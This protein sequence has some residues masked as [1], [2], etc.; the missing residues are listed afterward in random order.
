MAVARATGRLS[1]ST[2]IAAV[3]SA[4]LLLTVG[5]AAD[6]LVTFD[7]AGTPYT[8]GQCVGLSG[9][10][11]TLIN[12][13]TVGQFMRLAGT[14]VPSHGTIAMDRSNPGAFPD[15]LSTF[16]IRMTSQKGR[17][18]GMGMALL[19]TAV[20]GTKGAVCPS[21]APWAAEQPNFPQSLGIGFDIYKNSD[22]GDLNNN[23][24]GIHFDG[25]RVY[26]VDA[27]PIDLASGQWITVVVRVRAT[28]TSSSQV[29][30]TLVPSDG[31][32]VASKTYGPFPVTGLV[33]YE[34]R[35]WFG[36]RSGGESAWQDLDDV[37]VAYMS[38]AGSTTPLFGSVTGMSVN[39]V[40]C[41]NLATGQLV[42][43][44]PT[45]LPWNCAEQ[46]LAGHAGDTVRQTVTGT[47]TDLASPGGSPGP[48]PSPAPPLGSAPDNDAW[49]AATSIGSLPFTANQSV[50]GATAEAGEQTWCG[51]EPGSVWFNYTT[52]S[53]GFVPPELVIS[54]L[55]SDFQPVV[56]VF[57][58]PY[59]GSPSVDRL[60]HLTCDVLQTAGTSAL[61]L[62][63]QPATTYSVQVRPWVPLNTF[64]TG[65][66]KLSV[67][68]P[69]CAVSLLS[70]PQNG[71][72]TSGAGQATCWSTRIISAAPNPGFT[73]LNWTE[74]GIVLSTAAQLTVTLDSNRTLTAHFQST[75]STKPPSCTSDAALTAYW[76]AEG[77]AVNCVDNTTGVFVSGATTGPGKLG[78]GFLLN[79]TGGYLDMKN[80]TNVQ[81][82]NSPSGFS[83]A[84]FVRFNALGHPPGNN[85]GGPQGDMSIVDKMAGPPAQ[86]INWEGWRLLKQNDNHFWFCLGGSATSGVYIQNGCTPDGLLTVR[87]SMTAQTGIW[88]HLVAVKTSQTLSLYVNGVLD[89]TRI[90]PTDVNTGR[91]S[92]SLRIGSYV[93]EGAFLNGTV[94]EVML[95]RRPLTNGEVA[96]LYNSIK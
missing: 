20:F 65:K 32:P 95:F 91:N 6:T 22:L 7:T 82:S 4:T 93:A 38:T 31:V 36:G 35:L 70:D 5:T 49:A 2:K 37:R 17:A 85:P 57:Q 73:F 26:Q 83:V 53:T 16:R 74:N 92:A 14:T 94:D 60:V 46:G 29:T 66:L 19:N 12:E 58:N 9:P 81:V 23:H 34:S 67:S 84:A 13:S 80:G 51:G 52:P 10:P 3:A 11:P 21:W 89:A 15:V 75:G 28:D 68:T 18:D 30:V 86:G 42:S 50:A 77:D 62:S 33:P 8:S 64:E 1:R 88:Y 55:G 54:A 39:S 72:T 76:R 96:A 24:I 25:T 40:T 56:S 78:A 90:L 48:L 43:F 27:G 79:G 63:L 61:H 87:S 41:E 71:G 45:T 44:G 47:W 59:T 69:Q